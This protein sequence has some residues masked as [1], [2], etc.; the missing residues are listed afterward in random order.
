MIES[1][2]CFYAT[3]WNKNILPSGRERRLLLE[4]IGAIDAAAPVYHWVISHCHD[5][6][7]DIL[8]GDLYNKIITVT[9]KDEEEWRWVVKTDS[10][11]ILK[12]TTLMVSLYSID[13]LFRK[14][15]QGMHSVW[16]PLFL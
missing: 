2:L 10:D 7:Q 6:L 4:E 13:F 11:I 15:I 14:L 9:P 3:K 1:C 5:H 8:D 12:I 16:L